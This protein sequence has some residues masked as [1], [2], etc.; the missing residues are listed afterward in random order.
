MTQ[1]QSGNYANIE[2]IHSQRGKGNPM[3]LQSLLIVLYLIQLTLPDWS[4]IEF[5]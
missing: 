2:L 3:K 5:K 1:Y 4:C